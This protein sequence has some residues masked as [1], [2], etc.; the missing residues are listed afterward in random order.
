MLAGNYHKPCAPGCE[1][2]GNCNIEEGRCECPYGWAG[3]ACEQPV[4]PACRIS[5]SSDEVGC[6]QR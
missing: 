2:R 3:P 6:S 4:F 1:E 5:N